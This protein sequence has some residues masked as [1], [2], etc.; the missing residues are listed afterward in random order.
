MESKLKKSKGI[1]LIALVITI[2]VLIILAVVSI[3]IATGEG[4]I[5][6]AQEAKTKT[7]YASAEEKLQIAVLG[8]YDN[9]G[10]LSLDKLKEEVKSEGGT[11]TGDTFPVTVTMDGHT[12]T[13]D[14]KG[15]VTTP[16]PLPEGLE[17]GSKV[18]Y[19]P[20][21]K[22]NWQGKYCSSGQSDTTLNSAEANFKISEWRVLDIENGK[23]TL[24]PTAPTTGTVYLGETQGYNNGVKLLNDACNSLYG[25]T[26]RG[27]TARSLNIDDIEKYMTEEAV[28]SAHEDTTDAAKYGEQ[29]TNPYTSCK[30]YPII[31]A[32]ENLSYIN[33]GP[34]KKDGLGMSEQTE[35]VEKTENGGTD[36]KITTATSIKP[37]QTYWHKDYSFMQTAFKTATNG[38]KY[39]NLIMPKGLSPTYWLASRCVLTYSLNCNYDMR[40]VSSGSVSSQLMYSSSGDTDHNRGSLALFPAVSLSS[41]LISG[42]ATTGFTVQ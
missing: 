13:V 4:L 15:T 8:S 7:E 23:V 26:A 11:V 31:Y 5:N 3:K 32:K 35:F 39:Y 34:E 24:V 33:N 42:D 22:Y 17:I 19:T 25:N 30:N 36:G 27:I 37:Y 9:N 40:M 18:T 38:T 28:K 12:F 41:E 20:S 6:K 10:D 21:G 2:I 29:V 1:T 16:K 14:A